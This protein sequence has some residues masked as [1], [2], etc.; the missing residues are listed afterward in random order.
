MHFIFVTSLFCLSFLFPNTKF[1]SRHFEIDLPEYALLRLNITLFG[2]ILSLCSPSYKTPSLPTLRS[3]LLWPLSLW[4]E[5]HF[6]SL[7]TRSHTVSPLASCT[8][9]PKR[10]N[11]NITIGGPN[12]TKKKILLKGLSPKIK[13]ELWPRTNRDNTYAE[14]YEHAYTAESVVINKDLNEDKGLTA[15]IAG[16]SHHERRQ[17]KEIEI[18]RNQIETMKINDANTKQELQ[19]QET[20]I[21]VA[22]RYQPRRSFFRRTST[23]QSSPIPKHSFT[24]EQQLFS[25]SRY[26]QSFLEK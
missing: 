21:A 12:E 1:I 19:G 6:P 9:I 24:S 7:I 14:L 3:E 8:L 22:D 5:L 13:Q 16:M 4:L 10:Q 25:N 11:P 23:R 26:W 2:C 20:T 15:V 17:D 18:L